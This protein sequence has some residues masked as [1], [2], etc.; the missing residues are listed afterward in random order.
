LRNTYPYTA[1]GLKHISNVTYWIMRIKPINEDLLKVDQRRAVDFTINEKIAMLWAMQNILKSVRE[2][3]LRELICDTD[4]NRR[5]LEAF[6]GYFFNSDLYTTIDS[7]EPVAGTSK[8][9][10]T[11]HYC[12]FKKITA[13]NLYEMFMQII[14]AVNFTNRIPQPQT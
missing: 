11:V 9:K 6:L 5:S 1:A 4:Q 2:N 13:I 7:G 3:R 14:M 10:E 8:F 12:R